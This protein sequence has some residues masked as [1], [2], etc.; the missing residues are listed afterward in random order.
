MTTQPKA[1]HTPGPWSVEPGGPRLINLHLCVIKADDGMGPVA[2]AT[3]ADAPL[4][5]TAPDL[6]EIVRVT[7][8]NVKSLGP[9]GALEGV[10]PYMSYREW[11]AQLEAVYARATGSPQ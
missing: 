11:L 9:A 6:L 5:A 10:Q 7:I 4:V 3:K 8:G 2:F 1:G